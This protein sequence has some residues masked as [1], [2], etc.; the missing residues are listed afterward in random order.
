MFTAR[1]C[2]GC[3]GTSQQ[4]STKLEKA[5]WWGQEVGA[6]WK[7]STCVANVC[8]LHNQGLHLDRVRNEWEC[9]GSTDQSKKVY[10]T[11]WA[12]V[13]VAGNS[14][15]KYIVNQIIHGSNCSNQ[16]FKLIQIAIHHMVWLIVFCFLLLMFLF[17]MHL[18]ATPDCSGCSSRNFAFAQ[19]RYHSSWHCSEK[20]IL[21][22]KV[23]W[24]GWWLLIDHDLFSCN[25]DW[26]SCKIHCCEVMVWGNVTL[27][28]DCWL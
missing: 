2:C 20:Y 24:Q 25:I 23:S 28:V 8:D 15:F 11:R 5:V 26:P 19:T 21:G 6:S 7:S 14:Y 22:W 18:I 9:W 27:I 10:E 1:K 17:K 3:Q 12:G 4:V 13:C 16:S